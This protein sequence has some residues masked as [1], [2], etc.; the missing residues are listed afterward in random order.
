MITDKIEYMLEEWSI[1]KEQVYCVLRDG[2]AALANGVTAAG[3]MNAH[4]FLHII[5]LVCK[6]NMNSQ[7]LVKNVLT[8]V[9]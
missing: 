9:I 1:A 2:D 7:V 6:E 3:L 5:H 4:C 8:K